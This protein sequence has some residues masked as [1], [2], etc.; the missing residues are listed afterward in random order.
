MKISKRI[1]IYI[2]IAL[3]VFLITWIHA[4]DVFYNN[5]Q[6]TFFGGDAV[7]YL[8]LKYKTDDL[9]TLYKAAIEGGLGSVMGLFGIN[10]LSQL[11][12]N[13]FKSWAL[14]GSILI[15]L[16]FVF[17]SFFILEKAYSTSLLRFKR[18][19]LVL[20]YLFPAIL[21][22]I[23]GPNKEIF[24]FMVSCILVRIS[25]LLASSNNR[26]NLNK[27]ELSAYLAFM[28]LITIFREIYLGI[29]I[30]LIPLFK[31]KSNL[32]RYSFLYLSSIG[33]YFIKPL[34]YYGN[35]KMLQQ[36]ASVVI[37]QLEKYFDSAFTFF[38]QII[39][40]YIISV[41]GVLY[42]TRISQILDGNAFQATRILF[43]LLIATI[44]FLS[45]KFENMKIQKI[46]FSQLTNNL[47]YCLVIITFLFSLSNYNN[48]RKIIPTYPLAFALIGSIVNDR[49]KSKNNFSENLKLQ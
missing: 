27:Y 44:F 18:N 22:Y 25:I 17:I 11:T 33:L 48:D 34:E 29:T 20:T 14:F 26:F 36:Q 30:L 45:F 10:L 13:L 23:V 8:F 47:F 7:S 15:N 3:F 24:T 4:Y 28:I 40:R 19:L 49:N 21:I 16:S 37:L 12:N 1:F 35:E 9:Q 43:F 6:S 41:S 42:P 2:F 38:L 31:Y 39:G 5:S 46:N 32:L